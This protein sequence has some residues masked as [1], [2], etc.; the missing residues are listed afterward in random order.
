MPPEFTLN[1]EPIDEARHVVAVAGEIDLFTAPELKAALGEA[2]ESG[3]TRIVVDP[4]RRRSST[5][6]RSASSSAR[7]SA[8][9][10]AR[11]S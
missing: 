2:L 3:R 4:P 11:A 1:S 9:A 8:C 10:R 5:R 6:R 7:S